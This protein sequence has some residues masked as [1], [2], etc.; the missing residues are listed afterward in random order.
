MSQTFVK[1]NP[2][3]ELVAEAPFSRCTLRQG[4]LYEMSY[5]GGRRVF[6][7]AATRVTSG[8]MSG[9]F[10]LR[11]SVTADV[12]DPRQWDP[13]EATPW[14]VCFS[15]S[16][17][18]L[19]RGGFLKRI[20]K[21]PPIHAGDVAAFLPWDESVDLGGDG[22]A[23]SFAVRVGRATSTFDVLDMAISLLLM[24]RPDYFLL[25][26]PDWEIAEPRHFFCSMLDVPDELVR[27]LMEAQRDMLRDGLVTEH[28]GYYRQ[29]L[30]GQK[31]RRDAVL[32]D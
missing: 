20:G 24:I 10:L 4:D 27:R 12:G 31:A 19:A 15:F 16:A 3:R 26:R 14:H 29:T 11:A 5:P 25:S 13:A 21:F 28:N 30:L 9:S 18:A 22:M 2:V 1:V 7:A 17:H 8:P 32:L 6:L 23:G